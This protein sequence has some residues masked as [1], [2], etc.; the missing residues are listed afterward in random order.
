VPQAWY[1]LRWPGQRRIYEVTR[2]P[3]ESLAAIAAQIEDIRH[4]GRQIH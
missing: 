4:G 1:G 3:D 2:A